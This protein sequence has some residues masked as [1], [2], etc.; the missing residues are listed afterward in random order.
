MNMLSFLWPRYRDEEWQAPL[1]RRDIDPHIIEPELF[2]AE[3][4][5]QCDT[6]PPLNLAVDQQAIAFDDRY[7]HLRS[8]Y[9]SDDPAELLLALVKALRAKQLDPRQAG[10]ASAL[11]VAWQLGKLDLEQLVDA[12]EDVATITAILERYRDLPQR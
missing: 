3:E 1:S 10:Q 8:N 2:P 9:Q 11:H 4:L 5:T 7:Q 6:R 12:D